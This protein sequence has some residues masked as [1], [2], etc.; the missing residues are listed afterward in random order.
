[1][2]N[3]T[4][5]RAML[6]LRLGASVAREA[7]QANIV[8]GDVFSFAGSPVRPAFVMGEICSVLFVA[9]CKSNGKESKLVM[10]GSTFLTD[11]LKRGRREDSIQ[12]VLDYEMRGS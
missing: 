1:M 9:R 2:G 8:P 4:L 5:K 11:V 12:P 6:A 7:W 3:R 10:G